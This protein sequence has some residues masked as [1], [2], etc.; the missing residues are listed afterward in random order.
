VSDT[1]IAVLLALGAGMSYATAAVLQQRVAAEQAPELSLSPRLIVALVKRPLWLLGTAFDISAYFLEAGALAAGSII[2][3]APLLVSGLLFALPLATVGRSTR[4]TRREM[5]PAVM[6]TGGLAAFVAVGSPEG[7]R[8][9]ASLLGWIL[10]GAVVAT[11]AG[12]CVLLGRRPHIRANHRALLFGLATGTIYSLTAVL[13][14]ATVDLFDDGVLA[15]FGHWQPYA[16]GI[17]SVAGLVLNQSAFQ[18]GH[19]AASLPVIA[20]T[21]PVLASTFGILLFDERLDA[22][23]IGAWALTAAAVAAMVVGTIRLAR[24]PLVTHDAEHP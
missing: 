2:V 12:I 7:G 8:S 17:V 14:K 24:S 23:G 15:A 21:N 20:I 1:L 10:A 4:I 5:V 6:V 16:L 19:V 22:H 3:V 18:A 11:I 13:T 9:Q